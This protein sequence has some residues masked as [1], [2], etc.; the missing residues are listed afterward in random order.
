MVA[1]IAIAASASTAGTVAATSPVNWGKLDPALRTAMQSRPGAVYPVIVEVGLPSDR[2]AASTGASRAAASTGASRA[3]DALKRLDAAHGRAKNRLAIIG[4]GTGDAKWETVATLSRDPRVRQIS[5]DRRI[6]AAGSGTSLASVYTQL[7]RAPD[8]WA[9]GYNGRGVGVAV[10]DSGVFAS[11]DLG[12]RLVAC[13]DLVAPTITDCRADPGGHGSHVA[14][15]IAGNGTDSASNAGGA[16]KGIAPGANIIS[17]RIIDGTG[18]ASLSSIIRGIEWVVQNRKTYNIRVMNLSFGA[19]ALASYKSDPMVT[20][21]EIAWLS[22]VV[23]VSA[24]GNTGPGVGTI[25]T[26]AIDPYGIAVGALDDNMTLYTSDD[27]V[28]PFSSRG[29]TIDNFTKPDLVAPGRRL[30]SL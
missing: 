7:V 5:L 24:A 17:V 14:G 25:N 4:A 16:Y 15:I 30:I 28:A 2:A 12:S 23:V 26:P 19:T 22:G 27:S 20:A 8:V 10:I 11:N 29:P 9:L 6:G 3:V 13:V 21:T 18:S 1:V